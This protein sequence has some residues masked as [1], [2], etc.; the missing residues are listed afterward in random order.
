MGGLAE[1]RAEWAGTLISRRR[2]A[3]QGLGSL[4]LA[5]CARS[6]AQRLPG[7]GEIRFCIDPGAAARG[8]AAE[9]RALLADMQSR[10]G[11]KVTPLFSARAARLIEAMRLGRI[12]AGLFSAR[13]ALA[14]VRRGG[15]EVFARPVDP[16]GAEGINS[17]LIVNA[18]RPLPLARILRCDHSLSLGMGEARSLAGHV[19]PM[20]YLFGPADI[21][22]T[23]CFR[24]VRLGS[25]QT[26]LSAVAAGRLDAATVNS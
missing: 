14:A 8:Y 4:A 3:G 5:S 24:E 10:T 6:P 1:L 21:E 9:W 23:R 26:N 20:T 7:P 16:A 25:D 13:S 2:F 15:A 18:R 22:P 17:V 11:V 19:A 12:D